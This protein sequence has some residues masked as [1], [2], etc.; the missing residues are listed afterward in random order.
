MC[1]TK[2]IDFSLLKATA[3]PPLM[4]NFPK[5]GI[6]FKTDGD[7]G[8][9]LVHPDVRDQLAVMEKIAAAKIKA[10]KE[11]YVVDIPRAVIEIF[12]IRFIP[13]LTDMV[14]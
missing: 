5:C 1:K 2:L 3:V 4:K 8:V 7:Y 9:V 12:N 11:I 14:A 13:T 6:R 10:N